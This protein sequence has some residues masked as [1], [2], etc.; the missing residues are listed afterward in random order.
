M[1][2]GVTVPPNMP[3][4]PYTYGISDACET[5]GILVN[6]ETTQR[7]VMEPILTSVRRIRG[8]WVCE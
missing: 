7:A 5:E 2:S 3:G 1:A 4:A 8:L 6:G